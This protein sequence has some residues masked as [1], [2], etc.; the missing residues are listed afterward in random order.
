ML[1][2]QQASEEDRTKIMHHY[3]HYPLKFSDVSPHDFMDHIEWR[4][5][6]EFC[7]TTPWENHK[8]YDGS[9]FREFI[10]KETHYAFE[11]SGHLWMR[12]SGC[13]VG[14]ENIEQV[15]TA[16]RERVLEAFTHK[17]IDFFK[18]CPDH[19]FPT[20]ESTQN[21]RGSLKDI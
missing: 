19:C 2:H 3:E 11:R 17:A 15:Y 20:R 1:I 10:Q 9:V 13:F 12:G 5:Y 16:T 18:A 4:L 8:Y 7:L 21:L 6:T 14:G